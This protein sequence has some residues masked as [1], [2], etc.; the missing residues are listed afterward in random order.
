MALRAALSWARGQVAAPGIGVLSGKLDR[1]E[2][3]LTSSLSILRRQIW[4]KPDSP[5]KLVCCCKS[6]Q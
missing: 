6:H 2:G 1:K 4:Q 5:G 3:Q